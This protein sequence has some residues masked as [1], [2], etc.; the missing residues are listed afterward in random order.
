MP[1]AGEEGREPAAMEG[2][3]HSGEAPAFLAERSVQGRECRRVGK[4]RPEMQLP[5]TGGPITMV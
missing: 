5:V 2:V 3:T 4:I 1:G